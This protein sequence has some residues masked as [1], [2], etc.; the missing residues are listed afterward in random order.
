MFL[1]DS[2]CVKFQRWNFTFLT[3]FD[4]SNNDNN[5]T[6]KTTKTTKQQKQQLSQKGYKGSLYSI[7][8]K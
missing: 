6:T 7:I 2:I 8:I 1:F 5:K 3:I 4:N